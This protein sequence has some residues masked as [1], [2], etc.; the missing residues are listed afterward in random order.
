[1]WE[2]IKYVGTPLTLLAFVVA[3][4]AQIYRART[5]NLRKLVDSVPEA[6]RAGLIESTLRDFTVVDTTAMT[7]TQKHDLAVRALDQRERRLRAVLVTA[8]VLTLLFL[9]TVVA[10]EVLRNRPPLVAASTEFEYETVWGHI[11][12]KRPTD[13][14]RENDGEHAT[15]VFTSST[16]SLAY[17]T[18]SPGDD[19]DQYEAYTCTRLREVYVGGGELT[20]DVATLNRCVDED[21]GT[22]L[23][24]PMPGGGDFPGFT[25][26]CG[27]PQ[28]RADLYEKTC[29]VILSSVR[30]T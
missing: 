28:A 18:I 22:A 30:R 12:L 25:V 7:R 11:T 21:G 5:I 20:G 4:A 14:F 16:D 15:M 1:M 23:A 3:V 9:A 26:F 10:L 24:L 29:T 27:V 17:V 19:L 13:W 8:T 6:D 2:A